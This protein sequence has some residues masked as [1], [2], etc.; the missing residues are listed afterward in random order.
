MVM[1]FYLIVII[2]LTG[3]YGKEKKKK[4]HKFWAVQA[5]LDY[6]SGFVPHLYTFIIGSCVVTGAYQIWLGEMG[7][8]SLLENC[9]I[10]LFVCVEVLRPSQRNGFMLST[11]SL[12]NH[13]FTV[14]A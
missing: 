5:G 2:W 4:K 13:T 10:G 9:E 7:K 3:V 6:C 14:Q 8:N 1:C 11:V 12:P